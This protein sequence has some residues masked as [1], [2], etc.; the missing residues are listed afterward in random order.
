MAK[1][2][3][4]AKSKIRCY[5]CKIELPQI[6]KERVGKLFSCTNCRIDYEE[7]HRLQ[8][9]W[10]QAKMLREERGTTRKFVQSRR[11]HPRAWEQRVNQLSVKKLEE[12]W[13]WFQSELASMRKQ[14]INIEYRIY[15]RFAIV[16]K[17]HFYKLKQVGSR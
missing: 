12:L 11:E 4:I 8:R 10:R 16:R 2:T 15:R 5:K 1:L 17:V 13:K 7:R 3:K 9:F 14:S 6:L